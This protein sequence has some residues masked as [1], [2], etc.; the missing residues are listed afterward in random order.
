[1]LVDPIN[2]TNST[3]LCVAATIYTL[4]GDFVSAIKCCRDPISLEMYSILV[5]LYLRIQR[6]ELAEIALGHMG[7][8]NDD[9]T[10]TQLTMSFFNLYNGGSSSSSLGTESGGGTTKQQQQQASAE[11]ETLFQELID[12]YGDS[13][14]M[15]MNGKAI[16]LMQQSKFEAASK[17][18]MTALSKNAQDA[19]TLANLISCSLQMGKSM[20]FVKRYVQQLKSFAPKHPFVKKLSQMESAFDEAAGQYLSKLSK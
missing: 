18:L 12:K 17:L 16:S 11:A 10:I 13:I 1:M 6:V 8:F 7:E 14:V 19:E 9:A 20:E 3:L 15:L 5:V 2:G 4:E